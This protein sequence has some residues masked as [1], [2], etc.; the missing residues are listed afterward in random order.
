ME[1]YF[2]KRPLYPQV[3]FRI[4]FCMRRELLYRILN[5]IVAHESYFTQKIDACGRQ[6]LS[7]EYKLT[8]VI[9]MLAYECS[10]DSTDE[11][12]RFASLPAT[13]ISQLSFERQWPRMTLGYSM[14]FLESPDRTMISTS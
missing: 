1:D 12:C 7:P 4:W 10:T 6:S 13:S 5:D 11:Y 9:R 2:C 8:A 14:P 3:D